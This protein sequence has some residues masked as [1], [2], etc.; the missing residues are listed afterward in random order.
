[1]IPCIFFK[2]FRLKG[3]TRANDDLEAEFGPY[4]NGVGIFYTEEFNTFGELM[5]K[6][7]HNLTFRNAREKRKAK[8][9]LENKK[10]AT[11]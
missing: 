2:S 1:M 3:F 7:W 4:T 9:I 8:K 6:F 11:E 10:A 5:T